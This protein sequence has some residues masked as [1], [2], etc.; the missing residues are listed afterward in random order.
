V[1]VLNGNEQNTTLS[2]LSTRSTHLSTSFTRLRQAHD[3]AAQFPA[4]FLDSGITVV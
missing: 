3:P 2:W 4:Q 1:A